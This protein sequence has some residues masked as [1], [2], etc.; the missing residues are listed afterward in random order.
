MEYHTMKSKYELLQEKKI[1]L[2][3]RKPFIQYTASPK[4]DLKKN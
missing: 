3:Y 2:N 1:N 4:E